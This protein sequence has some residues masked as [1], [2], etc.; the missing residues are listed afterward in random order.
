MKYIEFQAFD[1]NQFQVGDKVRVYHSPYNVTD[2]T[3]TEVQG[4]ALLAR[5]DPSKKTQEIFAHFKQCRRL[6][7]M[8]PRE[9]L[10]YRTKSHEFTTDQTIEHYL[11]AIKVI[12]VLE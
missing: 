6:E 4:D 1:T 3:V 11:P 10:I 8:K 7:E 12:E 5:K 2:A 9:W